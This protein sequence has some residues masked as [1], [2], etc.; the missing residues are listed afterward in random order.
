[1]LANRAVRRASGVARMP[2][3]AAIAVT[4]GAGAAA[5]AATGFT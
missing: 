4:T 5:S 3:A 1:M 2:P